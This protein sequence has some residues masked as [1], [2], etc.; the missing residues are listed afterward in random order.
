MKRTYL[1]PNIT[2]VRV[3]HMAQLMVT[4]IRDT[5]SEE[6]DYGGAS[7]NN[8]G[9]IIRSRKYSNVWDDE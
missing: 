5:E 3:Q 7:S 1:A 4:S 6:V 2:V 8:T 9:N